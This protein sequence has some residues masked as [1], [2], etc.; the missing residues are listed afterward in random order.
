MRSQSWIAPGS[1]DDV[2]VYLVLDDFGGRLGRAWRL[3]VYR[4]G[5]AGGL[6]P[7]AAGN[8]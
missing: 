3:E 1:P 2:E 8:R 7:T 5:V 4:L 6:V